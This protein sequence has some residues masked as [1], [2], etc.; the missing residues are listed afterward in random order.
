MIVK[1]VTKWIAKVVANKEI[2]IL[3]FLV[4][5]WIV[6]FIDSDLLCVVVFL[7]SMVVSYFLREIS[8]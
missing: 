3:E 6:P 5:I 4:L 7:L 8:R 2:S 1:R